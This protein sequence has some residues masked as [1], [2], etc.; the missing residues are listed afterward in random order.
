MG[1]P[2]HSSY[3]YHPSHSSYHSSYHGRFRLVSE[4]SAAAVAAATSPAG[5]GVLGLGVVALGLLLRRRRAQKPLP[6][7]QGELQLL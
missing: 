5:M 4:G 6:V 7:Q 3:S 2:V 1:Q